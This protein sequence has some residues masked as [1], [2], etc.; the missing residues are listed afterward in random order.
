[1]RNNNDISHTQGT[2]TS[3]LSR[4][5]IDIFQEDSLSLLLFSLSLAPFSTKLNNA[6]YGYDASCSQNK[7]SLLEDLEMHAEKDQ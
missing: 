3:S 5:R 6:N 1:M 4:I 2:S 7:P